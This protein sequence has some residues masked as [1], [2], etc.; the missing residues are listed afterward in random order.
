[1][2]NIWLQSAQSRSM[3]QGSYGLQDKWKRIIS[4]IPT[5]LDYYL[6]PADLADLKA[7]LQDDLLLTDPLARLQYIGGIAE[8]N[9]T[10]S[11]PEALNFSYGQSQYPYS[12]QYSAEF[13]FSNGSLTV[14]QKRQQLNGQEANFLLILV[15]SD[16]QIITT[17]SDDGAGNVV[18]A[19]F[20]VGSFLARDN[21]IDTGAG[22]KQSMQISFADSN[23]FNDG[24]LGVWPAGFNVARNLKPVADAE[25]AALS[26]LVARVVTVVAMDGKTNLT[27]K[28]ESI[29]TGAGAL[30]L[31][32]GTVVAT[33]AALTLTSAVAATVNGVKGA[34]LTWSATGYP[35][36]GDI[37]ITWE[38][39]TIMAAAGVKFYEVVDPLV[40]TV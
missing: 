25:L 20:T 9:D 14:Q 33:G 7:K 3:N 32:K 30:T 21:A 4:V 37:E 28:Y 31:W 35:V 24:N 10:S 38:T 8:A 15:D 18:Y 22:Y 26:T 5:P 29:L 2:A 12:G 16:N 27:D 13:F 40:M 1:M 11:Q 17:K 6:E 23:E 19:G 36:S 39:P 34:T